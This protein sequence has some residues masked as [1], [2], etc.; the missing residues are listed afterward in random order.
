M[1]IALVCLIG[2]ACASFTALHC[3][4][5]EVSSGNARKVVRSVAPV[6]PLIAKRMGLSGTVR[7]M[8]FVAPDGTVKKVQPVG[9]SPVLI[10]AAQSAVSQWKYAPGA[11]SQETI[12]IHFNSH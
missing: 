10:E 5:Q 2:L 12:E 8:A 11:E 1:R 7:V 9:G 6:Y 3:Q 4:G